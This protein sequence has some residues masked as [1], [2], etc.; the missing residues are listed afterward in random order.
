[1][2]SNTTDQVIAAHEATSARLR[3]IDISVTVVTVVFVLLRFLSRWQ[4]HLKIGVDDYLIA[5]ALVGLQSSNPQMTGS[6][7]LRLQMLLFANLALNLISRSLLLC[8][9]HRRI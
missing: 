1:M 8:Y 6:P 9:V 5:I 2:A 4:R 7:L 3:A